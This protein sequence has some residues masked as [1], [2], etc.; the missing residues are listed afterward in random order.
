MQ[1]CSN[2]GQQNR[3]GVIFCENCGASLIGKLP[4]STKALDSTDSEQAELGI[5]ASILTDVTIR[6]RRRSNRGWACG[7]R[8]RAART[9]FTSPPSRRRSSG[10]RDPATGDKPD[11]DLTPYAGYR[12][13]VS[14]R[15][16][17]IRPGDES[18]LDLWDLG[19]SNGTFLNGQRLSA[20]RPYPPARRRR[21]PPGQMVIRLH[22]E[23]ESSRT[24]VP[25]PALAQPETPPAPVPG[26]ERPTKP[27]PPEPA[28]AGAPA[29]SPAEQP[30]A[31]PAAPSAEKP[32]EIAAAPEQPP[33]EAVAP[34]EQPAPA[35]TP[36]AASARPEKQ[37]APAPEA[38]AESEPA[39]VPA[40]PDSPLTEPPVAT[41][42]EAPA[43]A[44]PS[45][46]AEPP[47]PPVE[48]P[49]PGD[50]KA[51]DRSL[52]LSFEGAGRDR[53]APPIP[54]CIGM[55]IPCR[56]AASSASG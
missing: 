2:C 16:A 8:S 28:L 53:P 46:P 17:A 24:P 51:A 47:Q 11:I 12:M 45:L 55:R 13:G 19:S 21:N 35:T 14:R 54:P 5:D 26:V 18:G 38:P 50:E 44:E 31:E 52:P 32:A 22:F 42:P 20:H 23:R 56:R 33:A 3:P 15:H 6:D 37:A 40:P 29:A 25:A 41:T 49:K 34:A 48:P 27:V 1:K 4:L 9:Q 36:P 10:R 7:W 39:A 30:A 43:P